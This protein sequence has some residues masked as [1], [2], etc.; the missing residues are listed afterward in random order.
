MFRTFGISREHEGNPLANKHRE[1]HIKTPNAVGY[2]QNSTRSLSAQMDVP[3][4]ADM[5][6]SGISMRLSAL[7]RCIFDGFAIC[8][9]CFY[10]YPTY[11]TDLE[12]RL[13]Q[14]RRETVD[15]GQERNTL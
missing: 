9:M 14:S 8:G 2:S 4:D 13:E 1:G 12:G 3:A 6:R 5:P 7:L 11:E 15:G 10:G